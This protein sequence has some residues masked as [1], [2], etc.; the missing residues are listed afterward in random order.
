M[1]KKG[2][3]GTKCSFF[4]MVVKASVGKNIFEILMSFKGRDSTDGSKNGVL[5]DNGGLLSIKA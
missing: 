5:A 1:L 4:I 3:K 2:Y